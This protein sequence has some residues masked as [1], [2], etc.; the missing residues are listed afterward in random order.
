MNFRFNGMLLRF[1]DYDRTVDITAGT[2]SDALCQLRDRYPRLRP[3]LW[4]SSGNLVQVHRLVL[5]GSIVDGAAEDT[6]LQDTDRV[7]ILTAVAG[8]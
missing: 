1:V 3:V 7:E 5:N 4:D 8:G 6:P 2:L